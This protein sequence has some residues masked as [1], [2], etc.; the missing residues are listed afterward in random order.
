MPNRTNEDGETKIASVDGLMGGVLTKLGLFMAAA[1]V[2]GAARR[3][4]VPQTGGAPV[5]VGRLRSIF[6][7]AMFGSPMS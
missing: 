7:A 1:S 2:R 6:W 4:Y 5:P 3:I